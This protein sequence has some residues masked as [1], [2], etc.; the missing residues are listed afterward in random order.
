MPDTIDDARQMIESRLAEIT[1]EAER[2]ERAL[3]HLREGEGDGRSPRR[4]H[5][6]PLSRSARRP[7]YRHRFTFVCVHPQRAPISP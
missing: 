5:I 3:S 7:S 1:D 2:L 6:R 4:D